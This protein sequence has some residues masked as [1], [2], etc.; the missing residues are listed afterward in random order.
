MMHPQNSNNVLFFFRETQ[1][2]LSNLLFGLLLIGLIFLGLYI[3]WKWCSEEDQDKKTKKD[4]F[5]M[6]PVYAHEI[7]PGLIVLQSE[8]GEYF[9]ILREYDTSKRNAYGSLTPQSQ[10][11]LLQH[12]DSGT[13]LMTETHLTRAHVH[14]SQ[15]SA[16]PL[17]SLNGDNQRFGDRM[18][19]PSYEAA[20]LHIGTY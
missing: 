19:P 11:S 18:N 8:D 5:N 15:A 7:E 20:Q 16:P 13:Q 10:Q 6:Q 1:Y 2:K 12:S 4:K 14:A 3:L 9:K 17:M